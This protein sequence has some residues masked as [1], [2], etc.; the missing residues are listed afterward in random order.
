MTFRSHDLHLSV[1]EIVESYRVTTN[2]LFVH[3][4]NFAYFTSRYKT[5]IGALG[6]FQTKHFDPVVKKLRVLIVQFIN[7][8]T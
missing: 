7:F 8:N 4:F 2:E 5:I 6:K 1:D 3:S